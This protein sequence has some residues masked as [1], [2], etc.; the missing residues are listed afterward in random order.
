MYQ[1]ISSLQRLIKGNKE[2]STTD[3]S[4]V[5]LNVLFS[6]Y[7]KIIVVLSNPYLQA[8]VAVDLSTII[9]VLDG[10][11]STFAEFLI[12]NGNITLPALPKNPTLNTV[13]AKYADGFRAGYKITPSNPLTSLSSPQPT[14]D[15]KWLHLTQAGVDYNLFYKSCLVSIN[16][17]FHITDTDLTGIYVID[18]MKSARKGNM[19]QLGIY[20]FADLGSISL[21]P[22]TSSML[23]KQKPDQLFKDAVHIDLGQDISKKTVMLVLGGY[24]HVLD[25]TTFTPT[26]NTT[27]KIDISNLPLLDRFYESK[28]TLDL[29]SL[30]LTSV[31][32]NTDQ[33]SIDEFYSDANITAYLTISQSFFVILDNDA[34]FI[35]TVPIHKTTI[36]GMYVAHSVPMYPLMGKIGRNVNYWSVEED[37]QYSVTCTDCISNNYVYG[38]VDV[39]NE[40]SIDSARIPGNAQDISDL[41]FLEVGSVIAI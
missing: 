27:I 21:L 4:N 34:V 18:G 39:M 28:G 35:K 22:I 31:R 17:F 13:T 15:K 29:S 37:G 24:L 20:S 38:T 23:Y 10:M 12:S 40:N 32:R 1:Y 41:Y 7:S 30:P 36:P 5:P 14:S 9:P 8:N 26:S 2:W 6:T 3:I 16:G 33:V 19:N 25:N 11:S